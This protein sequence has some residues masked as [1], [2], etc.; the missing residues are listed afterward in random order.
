MRSVAVDGVPGSE[1]SDRVVRSGPGCLVPPYALARQERDPH[2][3]GP[4]VTGNPWLEGPGA[5]GS[6]YDRHFEE[7]A[8]AGIDVHGEA[9]L[10]E[11]Y[12]VRSVL[13]AGC[14]TGRVAV[15]LARRGVEVVG[16]D[17]DG[18][19]LDAARTKA[20]GLA[21]VEADLASDLDL[22]RRF[23]AV[24]MAGNVIIFVTPGTEGLVLATAARHLR[25]GGLVVAGFA[26]RPGSLGVETYDR[27]ARAVGLD[28]EERWATWDRA[29]FGPEASY[30][31]SAHRLPA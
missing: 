22:G 12:G 26:L 13:D 28:L 21:W 11:S 14:G 30:A 10:V 31:V 17:L 6:D 2:R 4:A 7:L 3:W 15:E 20:P 16:V 25:A 23:D 24:V 29:P 1:R 5:R 19:M 8:A 9:T 27:E 18:S